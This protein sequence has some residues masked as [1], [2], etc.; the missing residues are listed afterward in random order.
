MKEVAPKPLKKSTVTAIEKI[1]QNTSSSVIEKM[2]GHLLDVKSD[3]ALAMRI[4]IR[5]A[6]FYKP[7]M[8]DSK[9]LGCLFFFIS[10]DIHSKFPKV[11]RI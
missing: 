4:L 8:T 3:C 11:D 2:C 1:K 7:L 6:A 9:E 10:D 5:D